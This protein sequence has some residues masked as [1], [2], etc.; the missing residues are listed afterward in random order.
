MHIRGRMALHEL[1]HAG[2]VVSAALPENLDSFASGASSRDPCLHGVVESPAA[3]AA[4]HDEEMLL[5]LVKSVELYSLITVGIGIGMYVRAYR[6]AAECY[7]VC[8]EE[9]VHPF[10]CHA[11]PSD[12]PRKNL[13]RQACNVRLEAVDYLPGPAYTFQYLERHLYVIQYVMQVELALK[14]YYRKAGDL[15]SGSR[16]FLHLHLP[17]SPDEQDFG[18]RI[19]FPEL[20]GY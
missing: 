8:R 4:S 13:V 19:D 18:F 9:L 1:I 10:V 3:E 20:S 14:P 16:D 17:F 5:V 15:E 7:L 12:S 2:L 6:I 11:D